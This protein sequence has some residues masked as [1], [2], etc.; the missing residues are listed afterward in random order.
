MTRFIGNLSFD[1]EYVESFC[2]D[3]EIQPEKLKYIR[4]LAEKVKELDVYE[5]TTFDANLDVYRDYLDDAETAVNCV[6]E[7][8]K[9]D[10]NYTR[11]EC[12]LLHVSNDS[13]RYTGYLKH[14]NL[15]FTTQ[16][17]GIVEAEKGGIVFNE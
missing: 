9:N 3:F 15:L 4:E 5:V 2:Y 11:V 10:K 8:G 17:I 6:K 14:T 12:V 7:L 13:F 1:D 16:V